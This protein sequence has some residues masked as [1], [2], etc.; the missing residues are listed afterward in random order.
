MLWIL[1]SLETHRGKRFFETLRARADFFV[2][3]S[4]Y[5]IKRISRYIHKDTFRQVMHYLFHRLLNRVLSCIT[6]SEE[7]LRKVMH[8]NKRL[9]KSAERESATRTQLEELTLH[10]AATSLTDDQK[11]KRKEKSL[12]GL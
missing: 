2:F 5:G 12:R 11:K 1:F 8:I 10:K 3:K 9:A 6:W 4:V 7:R